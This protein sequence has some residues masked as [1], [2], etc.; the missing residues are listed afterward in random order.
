MYAALIVMASMMM[1]SVQENKT[2][3]DKS[4][5]LLVGSID[6]QE[7]AKPGNSN[8]IDIDLDQLRRSN[9]EFYEPLTRQESKALGL[10]MLQ[11]ATKTTQALREE[12]AEGKRT[13]T[14]EQTKALEALE[15]QTLALQEKA[16]LSKEEITSFRKELESF[17]KTMGFAK[18]WKPHFNPPF[19][20]ESIIKGHAEYRR[21]QAEKADQE[22]KLKEVEAKL[23]SER[24]NVNTLRSLLIVCLVTLAGVMA[25]SM[26]RTYQ[27]KRQVT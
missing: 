7:P 12:I 5:R 8:S 11:L 21:Q 26:T 1:P 24:A 19:S 22:A 9:P 15:K 23:A 17:G 18:E 3:P 10:L 6:P 13:L 25:W 16:S 2:G 14:Q 20:V 27:S 4:T